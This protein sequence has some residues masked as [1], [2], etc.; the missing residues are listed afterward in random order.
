MIEHNPVLLKESVDA[1]LIDSDGFYVDGTFGRGGH[2][3]AILNRLS[4]EGSLVALDKDFEAVSLGRVQFRRELRIT[5]IH[6]SF[7]RLSAALE[8]LGSRTASGILLDLG[9]SSPQLETPSRGF[10]FMRDG[11]LD[12]RLDQTNGESAKDWLNNASENDITSVLS[13]FGEERFAKRIAKAIV[14]GRA[15][16]PIEGTLRLAKI[17]SDAHPAWTRGQHPATKTFQAIRIFINKELD[18]L[19]VFLRGVIDLLKIGGRLVI[20]SFHSL[21][22]RRVKRFIRDQQRGLTTPKYLPIKDVDKKVRLVGIGSVVKP[23]REE[24]A[25][26]SRARSAVMRVA[27][28]VA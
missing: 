6:A 16:S 28:R 23:T 11:P 21:E 15:C 1:L 2:S 26:N 10:S 9:L 19:D 4:K 20:I 8:K 17:V 7:G 14:C 18:E 25:Y 5:L 12:M 27:E 13:Q 22:D 24:I 3:S